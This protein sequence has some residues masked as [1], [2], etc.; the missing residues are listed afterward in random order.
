MADHDE[1]LQELKD[2]NLRLRFDVVEQQTKLELL[3]FLLWVEEDLQI[4]K[5]KESIKV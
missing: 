5:I 2:E 3:K 1:A 4:Q